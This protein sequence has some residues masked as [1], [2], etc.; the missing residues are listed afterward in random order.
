MKYEDITVSGSISISGSFNVP[1]HVSSVLAD[2][3]TGSLYF[4]LLINYLKYFNL[5]QEL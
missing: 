3:A 5:E 2:Q 1:N 4:I